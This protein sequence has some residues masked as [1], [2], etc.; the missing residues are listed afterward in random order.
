MHGMSKCRNFVKFSNS[1]LFKRNIKQV[2]SEIITVSA[3]D[4]WHCGREPALLK[5]REC[6][7]RPATADILGP[8]DR[9]LPACSKAS[10]SYY[11]KECGVP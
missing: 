9:V 8:A 7:G 2:V 3:R 10:L 6:Y 11:R 5:E 1:G 4:D